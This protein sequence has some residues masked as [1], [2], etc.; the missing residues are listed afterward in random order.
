MV[1]ALRLLVNSGIDLRQYKI[2]QDA[3]GL[4]KDYHIGERMGRHLHLKSN[5]IWMFEPLDQEGDARTSALLKDGMLNISADVGWT[6][7]IRML[8][9]KGHDVNQRDEWNNTCP[10]S[11][12]VREV[13]SAT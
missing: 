6:G 4:L 9:N 5:A 7:M 1:S 13:C 2:W 8:V 10:S 3:A 12:F 11:L